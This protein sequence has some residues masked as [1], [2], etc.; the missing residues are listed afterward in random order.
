MAE[1]E[2]G[3]SRRPHSC[4]DAMVGCPRH[5]RSG[6]GAVQRSPDRRRDQGAEGNQGAKAIDHRAVELVSVA[7]PSPPSPR[8]GGDDWLAAST[9]LLPGGKSPRC[10]RGL[11]SIERSAICDT[12]APALR[13][14][15]RRSTQA[16]RRPSVARCLAGEHVYGGGY[17]VASFGGPASIGISD[18]SSSRRDAGTEEGWKATAFVPSGRPNANRVRPRRARKTTVRTRSYRRRSASEGHVQK[19][20]A[21]GDQVTGGGA[22]ITVAQRRLWMRTSKPV[23]AELRQH[24]QRHLEG[25][26]REP[27]L[28]NRARSPSTRI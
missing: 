27:V 19:K 12:T 24:A 28:Q 15:R 22:D 23:D 11:N 1:L 20:C 17:I 21:S 13:V 7:E 9:A 14:G 6:L 3:T 25:Q 18:L 2:L 10:T 5:P 4:H 8:R 16:R 26:A